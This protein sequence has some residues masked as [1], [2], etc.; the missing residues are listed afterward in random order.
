[1]QELSLLVQQLD[2]DNRARILE[3]DIL[4]LKLK[5]VKTSQ[6]RYKNLSKDNKISI[7]YWNFEETF[8]LHV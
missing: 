4:Q 1:M 7:L 3:R 5:N 8:Q 6:L 2:Q